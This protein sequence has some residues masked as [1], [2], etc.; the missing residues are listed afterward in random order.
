M[1]SF[2]KVFSQEKYILLYVYLYT[3]R[4][5]LR[6]KRSSTIFSEKKSKNHNILWTFLRPGAII[7]KCCIYEIT[8][9]SVWDKRSM[10]R[11][12]NSGLNNEKMEEKDEGYKTRWASCG[13]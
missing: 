7:L 5:V 4:V 13:L 6:K 12:Y 9:S 10:T 3:T 11:N 2:S 1:E 8:V